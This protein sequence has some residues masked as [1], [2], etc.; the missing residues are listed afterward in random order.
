MSLLATLAFTSASA[1]A[2][3]TDPAPGVGL[4]PQRIQTVRG[5][6]QARYWRSDAWQ[7]FRSGDGAGWRVLF[8]E[9]TGTPR[10]MWGGG[11]RIPVDR[12][13][14]VD[15]ALRS[16]LDRHHELLGFERGALAL[17]SANHVDAVDTWFV[18]YDVL[19]DDLPTYRGG[20]SARIKSGQL[21]LLQVATAP[22][23]PT[24]GSFEL[25]GADAV[26][27]AIVNGPVPQAVHTNRT[28]TRTLLH[29]REVSGH[30]LRKVWQVRSDTAEPHGIWVTFVDA[31]TGELLSVHNEVFHIDGTVLGRH[32]ERTI[33]DPLIDSPMPFLTVDGD[34]DSDV[35]DGD[36]EY[37][38]ADSTTYSTELVSP[39]LRVV[40][41]AG[42]E[43]ALSSSSANMTWTAAAA[44]Q[45]EI[46]VYVAVHH[47]R[48]WALGAAPEVP[49]VDRQLQ[50]NVN[51]NSLTCN[52]TYGGQTLNFY[53]AGGGCNNSGQIA[54]VIYHEWGHGFHGFSLQAGIWDGS[55]SEGAADTL[56][57]LQTGDPRIGPEF[58]TNGN[59]V[60]NIDTDRRYPEDYSTN[61]NAIHSNGLIFGATMWDLLN[62]L[63]QAEGEVTGTESLEQIYTGLLKGGPD[64]PGSWGEALVADDDDGDLT[65]GTPHICLMYEA[66]G[67]HGLGPWQG[68]SVVLPSHA[69]IVD[70]PSG[71]DHLVDFELL[72]LKA[73]CSPA[74]VGSAVV[75]YRVDGGDW[76]EVAATPTG[77]SA[78]AAI[79]EQ[80]LGSLV[81]YYIDGTTL[82]GATFS[83]PER[84]IIQPFTFLAGDTIE[85]RCMDFE[86][87]DGNFD[88]DLVSGTTDLWEWGTPLGDGDDPSAAASG[89]RVWGTNL[90]GRNFAGRYVPSTHSTLESRN[91]R[92][93]HFTD[94]HLRY[95][96]WLTVEDGSWDQAEIHV[97]DEL[98][99]ANYEGEPEGDDHHIDQQWVSHVVELGG[100]ADQGAARMRWELASDQGLHFGGWNI[101]DVC[102]VAPATP[103]NRLGISDF[104]GSAVSDIVARLSWTHP[105]YAP[106]ERVRVVRR[107]DRLPENVDDG[108]LVWEI[109]APV[110]GQATVV[111]DINFEAG[112][113]FYAVYAFD[114][115][116]WLSY[117]IEGMNAAA[118]DLEGGVA[119]PGWPR[120]TDGDGR[121]DPLLPADGTGTSGCGCSAPGSG[122]PWLPVLLLVPLAL[123]RRRTAN[124]VGP[125]GT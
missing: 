68:G 77:L 52:A 101:D 27:T 78:S 49:I 54:D 111:D 6:V 82:E 58:R 61:P 1:V 15:Q 74:G 125:M 114:G 87:N 42:A 116:D 3:S 113:S 93:R 97:N 36:G 115:V 79:P 73:E 96:R 106:V 85:V 29:R 7:A 107:F 8:D 16:W 32:H 63:Q 91:W 70:A 120:D 57:M 40:N 22:D 80:S 118:V 47:V 50:A 76:Q 59:P 102:L 17:V 53:A 72:A 38:V 10:T 30:E 9:H 37:T 117:T 86:D 14:S 34:S 2:P 35:T 13:E 121:V 11:V 94:V 104:E 67:A 66:F 43:G 28:A 109:E 64:I 69:P 124:Q 88:S 18:Q 83:I 24:T 65:N 123:R 119:P 108:D 99:W 60:R 112:D 51:G 45:A 90:G 92:T 62:A 26:R 23:T 122:A 31:A 12:A 103:D 41:V 46:D 98:V 55:L 39:Y 75:H 95:Q 21:V 48:D 89:E 20:I 25:S 5:P 56:A 33:S 71:S 105:E 4:E 100:L 84:A 44:T 110:L 81:E 19:R